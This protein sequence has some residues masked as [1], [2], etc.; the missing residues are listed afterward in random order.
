MRVYPTKEYTVSGSQFLFEDSNLEFPIMTRCSR[1]SLTWSHGATTLLQAPRAYSLG[2]DQ[3][4]RSSER[5]TT[6]A[7]AA[8]VVRVKSACEPGTPNTPIAL[9]KT[10]LQNGPFR[11]SRRL[12]QHHR[13][14]LATRPS[15]VTYVRPR[16]APPQQFRR[17][18]TP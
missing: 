14:G 12:E 17:Q 9:R 15:A 11:P 18:S 8:Q 1:A 6:E 4:Y 16:R 3:S 13:G 7:G 2:P 10:T 5:H